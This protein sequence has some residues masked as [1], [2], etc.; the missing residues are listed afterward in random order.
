MARWACENVGP[1]F[2]RMKG[3]VSSPRARFVLNQPTIRGRC[4]IKKIKMK[5][6]GGVQPKKKMFISVF[7]AKKKA[8]KNFIFFFVLFFCLLKKK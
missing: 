5:H 1:D 4:K 8:E 6:L 3:G 2:P 7:F